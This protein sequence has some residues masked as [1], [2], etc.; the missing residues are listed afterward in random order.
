MDVRRQAGRRLE[1]L[2]KSDFPSISFQNHM[3]PVEQKQYCRNVTDCKS[4]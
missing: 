3:V 4:N 1:T 2:D